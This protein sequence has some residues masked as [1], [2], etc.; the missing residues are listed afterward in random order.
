MSAVPQPSPDSRTLITYDR[1]PDSYVHWRLRVDGE[2]ATLSMDVDEE[3][4][5]IAGYRLK[6]NSYDLGV[7]M[8]LHDALQRVRFEHPEVKVVVI[9]SAK[10]RMFCTGANIYMLGMSSHAWKVNFCKFTNETRNGIEDSSWHDG[11]RCLAAVNGTVAGGGYE[12][13]LAC[14]EILMIDDRS[15]TVSLPELPLL[16]VLPGTG[17]LTRIIDKR[18]AR[19]DL[20]DFFCTTSEGVRADRAKQWKL[21]DHIAKPQAFAQ[22]VHERA[23]AL[24][25]TSTRSGTGPGVALT[26]LQR[27]I[28]HSGYRYA[29]VDVALDRKVRTA[30]ITVTAPST[31]QPAETAAILAAGA[32][33]WPLQ[34]A[35]ELDDAILL[36]RTNDVEIG[37]W[38]FKTRGDIDAVLAVDQALAAHGSHW[39]VRE[40]I[41]MLRRTL[42]RLE[43]SSRTLFAIID[44]GSCF[45]GTLAELALAADRSYMLRLPDEEPNAPCIA[46]S[47][48]NFGAY[49]MV[50][51]LSR[52]ATRF[53]GEPKPV[54]VARAR[55]GE[56]LPAAVAEEL[57]LVTFTPDDLDWDEEVRIAIEERASLSPDALTGMEANLRFGGVETMETRIFGRLSAW[58]NWIFNRP[59]AVGE[60]GALKVFGT[61]SKAKFSWER[62]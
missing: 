21:V 49:P 16:G 36:L 20:A 4:G 7:D 9:T 50:N 27:K 37:T 40:T 26:P 58:Q 55:C 57:G 38:F 5:L 47:E 30:T 8:E 39:F 23:A 34:M 48:M 31:P 25:A 2:V 14:D 52:L 45:A 11:L 3:K 19:R 56:K 18:K 17:G 46:L 41:G 44:Q 35:R 33:W 53:C 29:Y 54:E 43:V 59:N 6:L 15:S 12:L 42:A 60:Q 32:S 62:V 10:E 13:A 22:A 51:R 1:H 28:D 24:A 61:G